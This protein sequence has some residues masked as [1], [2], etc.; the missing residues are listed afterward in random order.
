L[1]AEARAAALGETVPLLALYANH[2]WEKRT[3]ISTNILRSK[4]R[5]WTQEQTCS[6]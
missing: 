1:L 3:R 5:R 6:L 2:Y 4:Q